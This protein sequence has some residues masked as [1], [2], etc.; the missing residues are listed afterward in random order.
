MKSFIAACMAAVTMSYEV[1]TDAQGNYAKMTITEDGKAKELY[2]AMETSESSGTTLNIPYNNRG[3]FSNTPNLDPTQ[4]YTPNLL[5]G[6][7]DYDVDLSQSNCG[8]VAAFYM[9]SMPGKDASGNYWNT[10]GYYYCD[11]NQVGGNYCPEFDIME[12]NQ[13]TTQTTPHSC[14]QP[15]NKGFYSECNRGGSC[16]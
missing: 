3:Y 1:V 13:W 12:A 15:S 8:C 7:V 11:A 14:S 9:V 4:F 5:G 2:V 6:A 10:D 16:W